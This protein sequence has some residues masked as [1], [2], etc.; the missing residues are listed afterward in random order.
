MK[1]LLGYTLAASLAASATANS[2][3]HLHRHARRHG[4]KVVDKR[5]P[6]QVTVVVVA[7][8][9][10]YEMAGKPYEAS[11]AQQCIDRGDCV[12][13][14]ETTPTWTPPPPPPP[15][16]PTTTSK[17]PA[18]FIEKP[19]T[20]SSPPPPP[21]KTTSQAP[22][23]PP[24]P[25]QAKPAKS[26]NSNSGGFGVDREFPSG[27]I[28]CSKFPSDYGAV[29][30]DWLNQGGWS[31][32]QGVPDFSFGAKLISKIIGGTSGS[33]CIT[34]YFCS[35]ACPPGYQKAHWPEAQGSTGQ[36]VG[37]LYCNDKG[38]L[39]LTRK[40]YSTLCM[41]GAGGVSIQN[42]LD[43]VVAT[44]RTDYPGSEAMVIPAIAQPGGTVEITNPK[45]DDYYVWQGKTTS[46]QY[47]INPKGLGEKDACVWTSSVAPKSAGNWA[48]LN[49]GVGQA[50]DG[51]T[52]IGLFRN[53]P[54]SDAKLD[55]NV[56]IIGDVTTKCSYKNGQFSN[57]GKGCTA[58]VAPGGKA[59]VR[60]F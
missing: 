38:Y 30:I 19:S 57:G 43:E 55:F 24:A 23:P 1:N 7:A 44:C 4:S 46:A 20:T 40:G 34:G 56:E 48:S 15:P 22:P 37:G 13:V 42:D 6:D 52:Y 45:Q 8:T 49:L 2:H 11:K 12:V 58:T 59:I 29:P 39:E 53:E 26:S 36:S 10:A 47:Y 60:Y 35:Y 51:N 54:T 32:L 3:H 31:S 27:E 50:A 5:A 21:P 14:G 17:A 9:T 16:K 33:T 25:S 41:K 28:E 18:Q